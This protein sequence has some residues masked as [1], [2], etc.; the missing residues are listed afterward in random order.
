MQL[1]IAQPIP[2]KDVGYSVGYKLKLFND[3]NV[4]VTLH[5]RRGWSR[6]YL[7][8]IMHVYFYFYTPSYTLRHSGQ[9]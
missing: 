9:S 6:R 3:F 5:W 1:G 7:T 4:K 2:K 8:L